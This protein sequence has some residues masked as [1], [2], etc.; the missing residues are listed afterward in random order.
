MRVHN[1]LGPGLKEIHYHRALSTELENARLTYEEEK[2]VHVEVNGSFAGLLYI[3]HLVA[4]QV[5]VEEKALSHLLT[6]E[7]AAQVITSSGSDGHRLGFSSTGRQRL[8]Y[9]RIL[10]PKKLDEW[11]N[12]VRRYL[13]NPPRP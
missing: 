10:P 4:G 8:E 5:I 1:A 7:E 13:W 12:R 6:D 11:Q 9:R 2:P 3:D